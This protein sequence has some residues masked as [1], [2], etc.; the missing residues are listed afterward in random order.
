SIDPTINFGTGA[1]SFIAAVALQA[2]EEILI[3][4]GF[5]EFS[6]ITRRYVARL[7]GGENSGAG[8]FNF[9][10]PVFTANENGTNAAITVLR[11]GGTAGSATVHFGVFDGSA[12]LGTH[13]RATNGVLTFA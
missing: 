5:T 3:A 11:Q 13:Y 1:N 9:Y 6:G 12:I 10:S 8:I 4:G 7:V 2:N